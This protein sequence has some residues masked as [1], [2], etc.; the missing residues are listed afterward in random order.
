MERESGRHRSIEGVDSTA[1]GEPADGAARATHR[2]AHALVL[3]ADDQDR[4]AGQIQL[5]HSLRRMRVQADD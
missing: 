1:G 2:A 5:A 4:R 3:V